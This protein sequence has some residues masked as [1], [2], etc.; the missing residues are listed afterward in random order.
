M[1]HYENVPPEAVLIKNNLVL[2]AA[3]E[4]TLL[5][6]LPSPF[7]LDVERQ[8]LAAFDKAFLLPITL[9]TVLVWK[10]VS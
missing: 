10:Q 8:S 3:S 1:R 4:Q 2:T 6:I 7:L 5:F 9:L